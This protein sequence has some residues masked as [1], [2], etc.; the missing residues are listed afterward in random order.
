MLQLQKGVWNSHGEGGEHGY[1]RHFGSVIVH[2]MLLIYT[3]HGSNVYGSGCG[4]S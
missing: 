2:S 4:E 3:P 1:S